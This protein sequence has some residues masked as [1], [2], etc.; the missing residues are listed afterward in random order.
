MALPSQQ[1]LLAAA[2]LL[3][4]EKQEEQQCSKTKIA[5][6]SKPLFELPKVR[7]AEAVETIDKVFDPALCSDLEQSSLALLGWCFH[8]IRPS[9]TPSDLRVTTWEDLYDTM[10]T[11]AKRVKAID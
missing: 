5:I 8:R 4:P 11:A 1:Q 7:L 3:Q 9:L 10:V 6:P 2:A